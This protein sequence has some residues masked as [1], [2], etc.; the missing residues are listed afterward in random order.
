MNRLLLLATLL[1]IVYTPIKL[2]S[3]QAVPSVFESV[4]PLVWSA[5]DKIVKTGEGTSHFR[6]LLAD[7]C[8]QIFKLPEEYYDGP[9]KSD[10]HNLFRQRFENLV[11][12]FKKTQD[13]IP[14]SLRTVSHSIKKRSPVFL[15]GAAAGWF[16]N[17]F[18]GTI[19]NWIF[20]SSTDDEIHYLRRHANHTRLFTVA[21]QRAVT[22]LAKDYQ[23]FKKRTPYLSLFY[24]YVTSEFV[25]I[26]DKLTRLGHSI[27]AGEVDIGLIRSLNNVGFPQNVSLYGAVP[28]YVI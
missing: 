8:W 22:D 19:E 9:V 1:C 24:G 10:C 25:M 20:G 5:T 12:M 4:D 14:P 17:D 6:Y 7:P 18:C 11:G 27:A 15:L 28:R 2:T 23:I 26:S 3:A 21:L 16:V 13:L